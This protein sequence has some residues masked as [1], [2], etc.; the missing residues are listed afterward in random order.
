MA[1]FAFAAHDPGGANALL[2]AAVGA[3]ARGDTVICF[4]AGPAAAL[5]R[6]AGETC[7]STLEEL[8]EAHRETSFD[9]LVSA[10]GFSDFEKNMWPACRAHGLASLAVIEAWSNFKARFE[11]ASGDLVLPDAIAAVDEESR[12]VLADA[13]WCT[14]PVYVVGQPHLQRVAQDLRAARAGRIRGDVPL[15]AFFSEPIDDDYGRARRG[16]D[17]F[18][19]AAHLVATVARAGDRRIAI[20]PHP[21]EDAGAW[22]R[23]LDASLS[24]GVATLD[25]SDTSD[26]LIRADAVIGMTSMVLLEAALGGAPTLSVQIGRAE[27][28]HPIIE[29]CLPVVTRDAQL[30]RAMTALAARI[31]KGAQTPIAP[32]LLALIDDARARFLAALDACMAGAGKTTGL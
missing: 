29:R 15:L 30:A 8:L 6:A 7:P 20:K 4:A 1:R 24:Q 9:L 27:T 10:T 5:W 26:L 21:R 13:P 17:Q 2:A 12:R 28:V 22:R 18:E 25:V 23:W 3:R 14:V 16:F 11:A 32:P 31:G 19:I